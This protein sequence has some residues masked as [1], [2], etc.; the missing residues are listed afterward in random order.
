MTIAAIVALAVIA[1]APGGL[2]Q[3]ARGQWRWVVDSLTAVRPALKLHD[4]GLAAS[5]AGT[6]TGDDYAIDE[7]P[8]GDRVAASHLQAQVARAAEIVAPSWPLASFVAV[9]PLSGF[10]DRSFDDATAEMGRWTDARTHR[11][12]AEVGIDAVSP[13][14]HAPQQRIAA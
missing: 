13:V 12:L 4:A 10:E 11:P 3:R 5:P 14:D 8:H 7:L 1:L 2:A 6:T 9:N